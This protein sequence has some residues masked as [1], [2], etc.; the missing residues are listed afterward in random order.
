VRLDRLA[1]VVEDR[2]GG[3]VALGHPEGLLDLEQLVVGADHELGIHL[4]QVRD[5]AFPAGQGSSLGLEVPV[6]AL[7]RAGELDEPVPLHR[8]LAGDRALG[9]AD[10]LVDALEGAPCTVGGVPVVGLAPDLWTR[11]VLD[12]AASG[13]VAA[14]LSS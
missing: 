4:D 6:H 14:S 13:M 8:D 11:G 2:P 3:Q 5:V 10:L 12:Y 7:G 9:L 1:L